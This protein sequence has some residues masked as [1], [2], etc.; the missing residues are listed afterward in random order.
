MAEEKTG[1]KKLKNI[2]LNG[3]KIL[4][5]GGLLYVLVSQIDYD[6]LVEVLPRTDKGLMAAALGLFLLRNVI[7]AWRWKILLAVKE[8]FM[9]LADLTRYYLIGN[10]FG[11]FVPTAVG[12]DIARGFYLNKANSNTQ[13]SYSSVVVE[14]IL[15]I[16]AMM[17]FALGV[18]PWGYGLIKD[19]VIR[20]IVIGPSAAFLVLMALFFLNNKM[21]EYASKT[22]IRIIEK[23]IRFFGSMQQYN[24]KPMELLKGLGVSVIYQLGAIVTIYLL[25]QAI[26]ERLPFTYYLMLMP[27]VWLVS[28]VP[29]SLNGLGVRE[30]IFVFLFTSVGMNNDAAVVISLLNL[31]LMILQG[32]VGSIFFLLDKKDPAAISSFRE[33]SKE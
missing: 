16:A 25:A 20:I 5:T 19:G 10:F 21:P 11:F 13:E 31:I 17:L 26:D 18:F 22:R 30:G 14:R 23:I 28:L 27:A 7:S 3:I 9:P 33:A 8:I 2:L 29:I 6:V 1:E 24:Q 12:G 15:G 32:I 4:V